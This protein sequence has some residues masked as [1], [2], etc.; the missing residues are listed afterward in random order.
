[1]SIIDD[2]IKKDLEKMDIP[3]TKRIIVYGYIVCGAAFGIAAYI[4]SN[5][6]YKS[7]GWFLFP[8][9]AII[10]VTVLA[11][12]FFPFEKAFK[13]IIVRQNKLIDIFKLTFDINQLRYFSGFM[14]QRER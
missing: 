12:I 6:L 2:T 8:I 7:E 9:E 4:N 14:D 11:A 3:I 10:V 1:M 5:P 13:R